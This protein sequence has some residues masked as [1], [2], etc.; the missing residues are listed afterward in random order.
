M[1][2][3]NPLSTREVKSRGDFVRRV[4]V[5]HIDANRRTVELA[6]SSETPVP[7]QFGI[8]VL[9]HAAG[10][11][12]LSRLNSGAAL[13]MD[14]NFSD[15]IGVI[16]SARID[17]DRV[18]R[19]VVRFGNSARANEIF[20]DVQDGIRNLVSVGYRVLEIVQ[21]EQRDA[22]PVYT[23]TSWLP[24]EISFVSVPADPSV[25]IGRSLTPQIL[26]RHTSNEDKRMTKKNLN[27]LKALFEAARRAEGDRPVFDRHDEVRY[28]IPGKP[29]VRGVIDLN[30][31]LLPKIEDE[32]G[33]LKR[34]PKG[35]PA[36][37][38]S[39]I[40]AEVIKQSLVA[41]AG[42]QVIIWKD[43]TEAIS[44]GKLG[45]VVMA[46]KAAYFETIEAAPFALVPDGQE[47]GVT[48][49][50]ISRAAIH[51]DAAGGPQTN[52]G[53]YG[54][55]FEISRA[56]MKSYPDFEESILHSITY[57]LPR[58]A[59]AVLLGVIVGAPLAPFSLSA[60]AAAAVRMSELRALVGT[61]GNGAAIDN[62]GVLRAAGIQAELTPGTAA[63]IVGTFSRCAI[64]IRSEVELVAERVNLD[65][66]IAFTAWAEF[67]ALTPD[68][69]RFWTVGAQ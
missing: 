9:S 32:N 41:Q 51:I 38:T 20:Q 55:R 4:E 22:G 57:G 13:L 46:S 19:A 48:P 59:D 25:G 45:D 62:N 66:S 36:V 33:N 39:T 43:P 2:E 15:Q 3:A 35:T 53:I 29:L 58:T 49:L 54:V 63:T 14:H 34:P 30:G 8:E 37:Q 12:D 65:G 24:Y 17:S 52:T 67:E 18:G 23:V 31:D 60:A 47:V 44:T 50:P 28:V 40:G 42:A 10:A 1:T 61:L 56:T 7:R 27:P 26:H 11:V 64:L 6:F 16:E 21:S 5:S 68:L 69:S